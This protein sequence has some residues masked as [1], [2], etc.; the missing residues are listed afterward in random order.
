M[1]QSLAARLERHLSPEQ[2]RLLFQFLR[3]GSVGAFG[4]VVD[5][6]V[7]Y[8]LRH[9][10]G[11]YGAGMVSYVV[12]ASVNWAI[13][14][15]WTFRGQGRHKAHHQWMLFLLTNLAGFVLNR[16]AYALLIH[17]SPLV[18]AWPVLAVAAGS[19]AGMFVNFHLS[20]TVAFR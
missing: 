10:L 15:A 19:L 17:F 4:F 2:V 12:A 1:S 20:R 8:A 7:V 3:F 14:R 16:G 13:N 9:R 6:A 11:L 18:R 5:T